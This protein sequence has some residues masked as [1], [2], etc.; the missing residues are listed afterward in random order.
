MQG[1]ETA[2]EGFRKN[3]KLGA[4]DLL[5]QTFPSHSSMQSSIPLHVGVTSS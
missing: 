2:K 3:Y 4:G 5:T 1:R